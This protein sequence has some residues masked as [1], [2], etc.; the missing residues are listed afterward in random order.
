MSEP[1]AG[2]N[3]FVGCY[4]RVLSLPPDGPRY[5]SDEEALRKSAIGRIRRIVTPYEGTSDDGLRISTGEFRAH[6][7]ILSRDGIEGY[8]LY[9]GPGDMEMVA[10][11]EEML[12][13]YSDDIWQLMA[14]FGEVQHTPTYEKLVAAF[15]LVDL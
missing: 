2:N 1:A 15:G 8:S 3:V 7:A 4:V 11:T 9:L 12:L 14:L 13:L 6:Y 5:G 10:P